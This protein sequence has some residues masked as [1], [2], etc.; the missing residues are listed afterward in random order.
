MDV[1]F[2]KDKCHEISWLKNVSTTFRYNALGV[3]FCCSVDEVKTSK[4][5]IGFPQINMESDSK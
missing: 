4:R 2:C 3:M 5:L 1:I